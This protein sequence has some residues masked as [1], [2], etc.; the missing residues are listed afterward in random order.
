MERVSYV[1]PIATSA[2]C[3][4][5]ELTGYLR[6]LAPLVDLV[7]VDGSEPG[8]FAR[9][10]AAWDGWARHVPPDART[11]NGKVGGVVTGLRLARQEK[12]VVADDDVR[13]TPAGLHEVACALDGAEAVVPQNHYDPCPP[14]ALYDTA[15]TLLHR[16]VG[17]DMPGT[18]A[19]RRSALGPEG[20]RGDVL[21]ENLELLRTV[22]ARGGRVRWRRDL[23]VARRPPET[24]HFAGQR[25]R[26]AYDEFA[27]P[28]YLV[29]EL[30]LLPLAV[31]AVRRR[32]RS[33]L[34]LAAAAAALAEV[35]RRRDGGRRYFS[36]AASAVAPLWVAE[37]AVCAWV[38]V[39]YRLTGG[40]PYRGRR[41]RTAA[42]PPRRLR[43]RTA[44][45]GEDPPSRGPD[46]RPA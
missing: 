12:V 15:R 4:D 42:S 23:L 33:A 35:G 44:G 41:L 17:G 13:W 8:V 46:A 43:N 24:G 40:V 20:Y 26:Q 14:H 5:P 22:R 7:V 1:L 19:V 21:F 6:G 29:A 9:N 16:A 2:P 11:R 30:A 45:H 3:P 10:H 36:P 25:V 28:A 32:P 18:L 37:R 34:A 31:A 39:G 27:R 38:A